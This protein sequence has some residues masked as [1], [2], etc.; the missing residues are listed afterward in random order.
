MILVYAALIIPLFIIGMS[1]YSLFKIPNGDD[2]FH[3]AGF[4]LRY[5]AWVIDILIVSFFQFGFLWAV[6]ISPRL[7]YTIL[8][9]DHEGITDATIADPIQA[10]AL[11]TFTITGFTFLLIKAG[12]E[13]SKLQATPGKWIL[14]LMVVTKSGKP[15]GFFRSFFRQAFKIF[16]GLFLE[17]GYLLAGWTR[18]KRGL[19]DFMSGCMVVQ[20]SSP[21]FN[22]RANMQPAAFDPYEDYT[23]PPPAP[24]GSG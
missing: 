10:V 1:L 19:H 7:A 11:T 22:K 8:K 23:K 15:I 16:S 4:W 20:R 24:A 6:G 12:F 5:L 21:K 14:G 3:Y 17:L 18:Q 13:S 9:N 2:N